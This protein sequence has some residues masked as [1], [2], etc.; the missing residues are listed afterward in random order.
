MKIFKWLLGITMLILALFIAF[1]F[2][3]ASSLSGVDSRTVGYYNQLKSELKASGYQDNLLIISS[4]RNRRHNQ[5]L[6]FFGAASNS[7]HLRGDAIDLVVLDV[8]GDGQV[9]TEDVDIVYNLLDTKILPG[10]GGL[11]TYKSERWPWNRQ[12]VHMD[13]REKKARWHR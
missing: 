2:F 1:F 6:T 12:M 5:M 7:R 4:K 13:C 3:Y 11:G 10:K 8:N 9:D